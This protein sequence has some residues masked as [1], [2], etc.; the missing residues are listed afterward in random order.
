[1]SE[2]QFEGT[3]KL[4]AD[5]PE[6]LRAQDVDRI[7]D[8]AYGRGFGDQFRAWLLQKN[9]QGDT[10]REVQSWTPEIGNTD[11]SIFDS[12][13]DRERAGKARYGSK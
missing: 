4:A 12:A 7:M 6:K 8:D 3:L 11:S 13:A 9:L 2:D 1:M 5:A 10:R